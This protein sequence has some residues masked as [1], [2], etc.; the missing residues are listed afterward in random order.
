M[1]EGKRNRIGFDL[2]PFLFPLQCCAL[3]REKR[4]NVKLVSLF[5]NWRRASF[6]YVSK[7]VCTG[8]YMYTCVHLNTRW[9]LQMRFPLCLVVF[10]FFLFCFA[11]LSFLLSPLF[12]VG[13]NLR[14]QRGKAKFTQQYNTLFFFS[15]FG[16]YWL[17]VALVNNWNFTTY[18]TSE[19]G[20][21][22]ITVIHYI[23]YYCY[24]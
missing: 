18:S 3:F 14:S 7:W 23:H 8:I 4:F 11:L 10:F 22:V 15:A 17:R 21:L 6:T 24:Y 19:T 20:L 13:R 2:C 9:R 5:F 12:Q 1:F 16:L